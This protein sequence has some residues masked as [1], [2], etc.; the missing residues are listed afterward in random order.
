[1]SELRPFK[2]GER[3]KEA[4]GRFSKVKQ[5]KLKNLGRK[6]VKEFLGQVSTAN[7]WT[8]PLA[9]FG[10]QGELDVPFEMVPY[11][12][13]DCDDCENISYGETFTH[14]DLVSAPKIFGKI[15]WTWSF[16][17]ASCFLLLGRRE[18]H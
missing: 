16:H 17:P 9:E 10:D 4:I 8:P 11:V 14:H 5:V 2:R 1:M 7:N 13:P 3:A 15:V 6:V 12:L 18:R